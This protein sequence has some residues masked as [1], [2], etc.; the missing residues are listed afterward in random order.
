MNEALPL[1]FILDE[2][3][4][5]YFDALHLIEILKA[6]HL[7]SAVALVRHFHGGVIDGQALEG[8]PYPKQPILVHR[9]GMMVDMSNWSKKKDD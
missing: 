1:E 7:G 8:K 3:G 9:T 6:A 5:L 4:G 2:K